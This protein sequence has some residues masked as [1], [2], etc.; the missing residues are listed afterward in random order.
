[1]KLC[2]PV[3][4]I[5]ILVPLA[6]RAQWV[7]ATIPVGVN[8]CGLVYNTTDNRVYCAN[9]TSDN[10]KVIAGDTNTVIAT[11]PVVNYPVGLDPRGIVYNPTNDRVYCVHPGND[12]VT[13]INGSTNTVR[14]TITVGGN[15]V[16][17]TWAHRV[18]VWV[19]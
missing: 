17:L 2:I 13:V 8:P 6:A 15:P 10:I 18:F 19:V 5:C 14:T 4:A 3:S 9:Q 7:E 1:M 11:I 16:G 12:T